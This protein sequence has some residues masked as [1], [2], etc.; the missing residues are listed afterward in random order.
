MA[1]LGYIR[2]IRSFID[3]LVPSDTPITCL[4]FEC[5]HLIHVGLLL[6][7]VNW[8]T[9]V[10]VTHCPLLFTSICLVVLH[11]IDGSEPMINPRILLIYLVA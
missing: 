7:S 5:F 10:N 6:V 8:M 3:R 9:L 1:C 11:H 4:E 2:H